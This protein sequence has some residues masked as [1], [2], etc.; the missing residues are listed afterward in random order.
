MHP[1]TR[2]MV[3]FFI[4]TL[5]GMLTACSLPGMS[6][7]LPSGSLPMVGTE[8]PTQTPPTQQD[9]CLE[10]TWIMPT[11]RL[12]LFIG[13]IIPTADAFLQVLSGQLS[14]SFSGG[15]YIYSGEFHFRIDAGLREYSD[16]VSTF[17]T[18]GPYS[19]LPGSGLQFGVS[20]STTEMVSCST[21]KDG[22]TYSVAC[23]SIVNVSILLPSEAPYRCFSDMLEIDIPSPTGSVVSMIFDR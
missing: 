8:V 6:P 7:E 12:D 22:I 21:T 9:A 10:G 3:S 14:M 15:T 2:S 5:A 17:T 18:S 1:K 19:S 16:A 13:T 23:D 20:S 11:D 4:L